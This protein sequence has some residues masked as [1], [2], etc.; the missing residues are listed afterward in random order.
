MNSHSSFK[1]ATI[2]QLNHDFSSKQNLMRW[3]GLESLQITIRHRTVIMYNKVIWPSQHTNSLLLVVFYHS[4]SQSYNASFASSIIRRHFSFSNFLFQ[5]IQSTTNWIC[6]CLCFNFFLIR[7]NLKKFPNPLILL[8]I[9]TGF[10][11]LLSHIHSYSEALKING[12]KVY[13][14]D[15]LPILVFDS[16]SGN[17]HFFFA[18]NCVE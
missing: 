14:N 13:L 8:L 2:Q 1:D 18:V 5:Q 4:K 11:L 17:S 16:T 9:L 12:K 3:K 10:S 15:C 7:F 6:K